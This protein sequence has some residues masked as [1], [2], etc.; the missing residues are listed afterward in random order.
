VLAELTGASIEPPHLPNAAPSPRAPAHRLM[1]AALDPAN[2]TD[3]AR[4]YEL[5]ALHR[6]A[7]YLDQSD[8][9]GAAFEDDNLT[10][11]AEILGHRPA[12]WQQAE[13]ELEAFV[14][15][16]GPEQD[17]ALVR[18][19]HRRLTREEALLQPALG[20]LTGSRIAPIR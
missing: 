10:D 6:V 7:L 3:A 15:G 5:D 16:A 4:A 20:Y 9:F 18:L 8:M 12:T 13:A 11:V 2:A 17:A 1:V 14:L 19:F